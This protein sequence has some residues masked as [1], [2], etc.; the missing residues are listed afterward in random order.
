MNT[1][2]R[3]HMMEE[4]S[5]N[6]DRQQ[7]VRRHTSCAPMS[8][9]QVMQGQ[10][11]GQVMRQEMQQQD[12][13][14]THSSYH[15]LSEERAKEVLE[16]VEPKWWPYFIKNEQWYATNDK[17][18]T[19]HKLS[20]TQMPHRTDDTSETVAQHI[21]RLQLKQ[22][23]EDACHG[24]TATATEIND[25]ADAFIA[26]YGDD[27]SCTYFT[28][29]CY[30]AHYATKYKQSQKDFEPADIIDAYTHAFLPYWESVRQGREHPCET[31]QPPVVTPEQRQQAL[32]RK[33]TERKQ[34]LLRKFPDR[35]SLLVAYN[36]DTMTQ[37]AAHPQQCINNTEAPTLREMNTVYGEGIAQAWLIAQVSAVAEF[38]GC[39]D[40]FTQQQTKRLA[41]LLY[42]A[43]GEYSTTE[44]ILFFY[45]F[46]CGKY[47][48]FYGTADPMAVTRSL[49][50]FHK[51][52]G[53]IAS[54][55]C[56]REE[57]EVDCNSHIDGI[58]ERTYH[59]DHDT[60]ELL[61]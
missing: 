16:R 54:V 2:D 33:A 60:D 42:C 44:F 37:Y 31:H 17:S 34:E 8:I 23:W 26:Q 61:F 38:A 45:R 6:D 57:W 20:R 18:P 53:H 40:K 52:R 5:H 7:A 51:E 50:K 9:G 30:F 46:M 10:E 56:S 12:W 11:Y 3:Q 19:L 1:T 35:K 4:M 47:A 25:T 14:H 21:V 28:I 15:P 29:M 39:K 36:P 59:D 22:V 49:C 27:S 43:H 41:E 58:R 24:K 48:Q 32:L 55:G 13:A